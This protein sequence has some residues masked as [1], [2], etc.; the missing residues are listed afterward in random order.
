MGDQDN[1]TLVSGFWYI[2]SKWPNE[3]YKEWFKNTMKINQRMIFFCEPQTRWYIEQCRE[4]RET[5]FVDYA[6]DDFYCNSFYNPFWVE[7]F[8]IPSAELGKIWHEKL[9][10]LKMA[11]ELDEKAKKMTDFYV[12]Y[13]A[14]NCLFREELPP[15]QRL[16]LTKVSSFPTSKI[17][18]SESYPAEEDHKVSGTV[19]ILHNKII[20]D[21]H[22]LFYQTV[23]RVR[24]EMTQWKYGSDQ[25]ILSILLKEKPTLF[26]KVCNGYGENLNMIYKL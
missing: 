11:K 12:W 15:T 23:N 7:T 6:I 18:Y 17:V 25:V 16:N 8:E 5:I 19:L 2:K 22:D 4:G 20:D 14:G 10:M 24:H 1:I 3:A 9:H 13:D 21:A 26:Y